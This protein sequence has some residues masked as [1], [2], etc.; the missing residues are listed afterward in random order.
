MGLK[1][2]SLSD[3]SASGPPQRLS[4]CMIVK[5]EEE[6]LPRCLRSV[7]GVADEIVIVDTGSTDRTVEIA[8][9]FGAKVI[10]EPW[11]GDFDG[12][13]AQRRTASF[14][15][16]KL[17]YAPTVPE[18]AT[19]LLLG[20]GV[21]WTSEA[22]KRFYVYAQEAITE[23]KLFEFSFTNRSDAIYTKDELLVADDGRPQ[24]LPWEDWRAGSAS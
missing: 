5:D 12:M 23:T 18:P 11:T 22:G 21:L 10:H 19:L 17:T 24:R 4:L 14:T 8:E 6:A 9:S 7:Q 3:S 20:A 2:A 16:L 15:S 1:I 13:L